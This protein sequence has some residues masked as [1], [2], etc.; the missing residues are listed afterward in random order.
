M[1]VTPH[2]TFPTRIIAIATA[3]MA[4]ATA[5]VGSAAAAQAGSEPAPPAAYSAVG[6][7]IS[8]YNTPNRKHTNISGQEAKMLVTT[9][10]VLTKQSDVLVQY[11]G[12]LGNLSKA[13][14]PCSLRASL[15]VDNGVPIVV[16]RINLSGGTGEGAGYVPDRQGNDGSFVFAL[17]PGRHDI[18]VI[19][20]QISGTAET[21]HAF[22]TNLQAIVFPN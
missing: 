2:H 16:K 8:Y 5:T 1:T 4:V 6:S 11:T 3:A 19:V 17:P 10:I 13:G 9:S 14:C 22:Y 12:Q 7:G 20:Q 21:V 18:S 15:V